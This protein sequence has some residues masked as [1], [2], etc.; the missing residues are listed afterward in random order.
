MD[1]LAFEQP[2][3]ELDAQVQDMEKN[4]SGS[5]ESTKELRSLKQQLTKMTREVYANLTPWQMVQVARHKDRPHTTDYLSLVFDEFVELH[6]DKL[7]GDDRA[8]RVGFA[9]LDNTK[10]MVIGHQKGRTFQDRSENFFGCAHPE[11]YRKAMQKMRLAAKF[12]LPVICFIDCLLYTSPS[13]RD[14]T[15]SRMPSSA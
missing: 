11:G 9:N 13:P 8:M 4:F 2:I 1:Y 6:G 12:N 15:L 10:V 3:A 14:A 7:F 5:V